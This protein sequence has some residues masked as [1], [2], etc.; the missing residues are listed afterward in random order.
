MMMHFLQFLKAYLTSRRRFFE[1]V[2]LLLEFVRGPVDK[3]IKPTNG[4]TTN[5]I[6]LGSLVGP[7]IQAKGRKDFEDGL[8]TKTM[9]EVSHTL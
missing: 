6:C 1:F 8:R 3:S 9:L 5:S 2:L 4:K 7:V